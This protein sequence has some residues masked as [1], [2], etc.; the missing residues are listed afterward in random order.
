M[1]GALLERQHAM[2]HCKKALHTRLHA[3]TAI[4]VGR[5]EEGRKEGKEE[6]IFKIY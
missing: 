5:R 6:K 1:Q 4:G 2:P 3:C